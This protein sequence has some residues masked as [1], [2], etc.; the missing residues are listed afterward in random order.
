MLS[1]NIIVDLRSYP[2]LALAGSPAQP[3]RSLKA[4]KPLWGI[5]ADMNVR[6]GCLQ[7]QDR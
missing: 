1:N 3:E 2:P 4:L 5:A 7:V 6:S